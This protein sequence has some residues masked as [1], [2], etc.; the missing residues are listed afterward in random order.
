MSKPVLSGI[1]KEIAKE[2]I[3]APARRCMQAQLAI[4]AMNNGRH[5]GIIP[6]T[7]DQK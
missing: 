4:F 7:A 3:D 6:Q 2:I 1:D 5:K